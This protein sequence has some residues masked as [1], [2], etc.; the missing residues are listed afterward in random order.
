MPT[1]TVTG[2][3]DSLS[4]A[5]K[6]TE[7]LLEAGIARHRIVVTRQTNRATATTPSWYAA[8]SGQCRRAAQRPLRGFGRRPLA[9]RQEAHR[10]AHATQRRARHHGGPQLARRRRPVKDP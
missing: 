3:F 7:E 1:P 2:I 10:R 8:R 5:E 9:R 6:V 4:D